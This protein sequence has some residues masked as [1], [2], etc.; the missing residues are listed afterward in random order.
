[1]RIQDMGWIPGFMLVALMVLCIHSQL[2]KGN[3]G[4]EKKTY[5][6]SPVNSRQKVAVQFLTAKSPIQKT[7]Y[8]RSP[9]RFF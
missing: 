7:W 3:Q 2:T 4:G 8:G 5:E 6:Y 9:N 1:M